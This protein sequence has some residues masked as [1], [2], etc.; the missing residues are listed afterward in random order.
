MAN[1]DMTIVD[2][3]KQYHHEKSEYFQYFESG[4]N[5]NQ[6]EETNL[7]HYA[8]DVFLQKKFNTWKT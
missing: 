1:L 7:W 6:A 2:E 3:V 8:V 4:R 5:V